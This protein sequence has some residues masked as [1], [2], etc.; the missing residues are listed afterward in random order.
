ME[1]V[2]A[3][4]SPSAVESVENHSA[5]GNV[6]IERI[7]GRSVVTRLSATSP[8]KLLNPRANGDC[9]WVFASTYGGGL[10]GGD[11]IRLDVDVAPAASCLLSTQASTKIYRTT[12]K[13]S[14]QELLVTADNGAI[15]VS[16][17][18]PVVC[19]AGAI[20][21][22]RQ[23]FILAPDARLVMIDW[24]T[25]GRH[26]RGERWAFHRF[27]SRAEVFIEDRCVFRDALLLDPADGA[28]TDPIRMGLI[29][30]FA[31]IVLVGLNDREGELLQYVSAQPARQESLLFAASP[32]ENGV[33]LRVAGRQ[34]E[35]VGRWIRDRLGFVAD[36]VGQD[37]WA[38]K[39]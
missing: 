4:T 32:I 26:A 22:Q 23:R 7:A 14:R 28:L 19:F 17:P 39:W 30:C 2:Q 9:A 15:V 6:L 18:D 3:Q 37:P 5:R 38:R 33:V 12:G 11:S 8:L 31:T 36:L 21:Q 1:L 24:F 27:D 25:S 13:A 34:T 29:D 20:Y 16:A 10:L 35:T